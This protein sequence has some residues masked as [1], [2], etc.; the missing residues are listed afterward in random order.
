MKMVVSPFNVLF[1]D[2]TIKVIII[3]TNIVPDG[4]YVVLRRTIVPDGPYVVCTKH[5]NINKRKESTR[6]Q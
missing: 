3:N 2:M 5:K 4:P 6:E 1:K